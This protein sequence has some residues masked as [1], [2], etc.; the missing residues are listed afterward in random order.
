[1][2]LFPL[3]TPDEI[4]A[5]SIL[6]DLPVEFEPFANNP[7]RLMRSVSACTRIIATR[8]HAH[9]FALTLGVPLTSISYYPKCSDLWA[10]LELPIGAQIDLSMLAFDCNGIVDR[11]LHSQPVC[12]TNEQISQI[13]HQARQG[14]L[15]ALKAVFLDGAMN[16]NL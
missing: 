13:R 4:F 6:S 10:D 5:R 15:Q 9:V 7:L 3:A 8:Y 2:F 11:L 1:M 14:I 16:G 12:L